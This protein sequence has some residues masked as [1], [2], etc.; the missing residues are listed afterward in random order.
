M[1]YTCTHKSGARNRSAEVHW[2]VSYHD[3]EKD[4][5][6]YVFDNTTD[7]VVE[8]GITFDSTYDEDLTGLVDRFLD[9]CK[10]SKYV[11]FSN[12][13]R[14]DIVGI[15]KSVEIFTG[16]A[17][18]PYGST[19]NFCASARLQVIANIILQNF[20]NLR[21]F[22]VS[23]GFCSPKRKYDYVVTKSDLDK[24][25]EIIESMS[26]LEFLVI[27][28]L[29]V[30]TDSVDGLTERILMHKPIRK[31]EVAYTYEHKLK[32]KW[33]LVAVEIKP[34]ESGAY[35]M[36]NDKTEM[37]TTYI[38]QPSDTVEFIDTESP[39]FNGLQWDMLPEHAISFI[40]GDVCRR[41]NIILATLSDDHNAIKQIIADGRDTN[42]MAAGDNNP[43]HVAAKLGHIVCLSTLA[44]FNME[45]LNARNVRMRSP[46]IVAA[47]AGR[48]DCI[49]M[50]VK[51]GAYLDA[52][53][54]EG[55][56]ATC[57]AAKYGHHKCL[58]VL[59]RCREIDLKQKNNYGQGPM[60]LAALSGHPECIWVLYRCGA[61]LNDFDSSGHTAAYLATVGNHLDCIKLLHQ[62][63][64]DICRTRWYG[65]DDLRHMMYQSTELIEFLISVEINI[66]VHPHNYSMPLYEAAS[67]SC[68]KS[69]MLFA[70]RN[71][72]L[73]AWHCKTFVRAKNAA[74]LCGDY[75]MVWLFHK[76]GVDMESRDD[77]C[78][79]TTLDKLMTTIQK[80]HPKTL[81]L[82]KQIVADYR[83]ENK[84]LRLIG[85][86][87][88]E[89]DQ[90]HIHEGQMLALAKVELAR[91]NRKSMI[92][93]DYWQDE[94]AKVGITPTELAD[95][96]NIQLGYVDAPE[97]KYK[98][99]QL[100]LEALYPWFD[101]S[102]CSADDEQVRKKK[103][104]VRNR[105]VV[106]I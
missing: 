19:S 89:I 57:L 96:I 103:K 70:T 48:Y 62:L 104:V 46:L 88:A 9:I 34:V 106:K 91:Q 33:D 42:I 68:Y 95:A 1:F 43:L 83:Y 99:Y 14:F 82:L 59:S 73:G 71:M 10:N 87:Q 76:F 97:I 8:L 20:P 12:G 72:T 40:N 79:S 18:D 77:V 58:Q 52:V 93:V 53:D 7:P 101:P 17:R 13:K 67:N 2:Y 92:D 75:K 54:T 22:K 56:S 26:G 5:K 11:P 64:A 25:F 55:N 35:M 28:D 37:R 60:H 49:V 24:L 102:H 61:R 6:K 100:D 63:G 78:R 80:R 39:E 3:V 84:F 21:E 29:A 81:K 44:A 94:L 15:I 66:D 41:S 74:I 16:R 90:G 36:V 47:D 85:D 32:I 51:L 86:L 50:L 105:K 65:H 4:L 31:P 30:E 27:D 38:R 23:S 45:W 69:V 98:P